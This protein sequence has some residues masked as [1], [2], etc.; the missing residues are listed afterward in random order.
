MDIRVVPLAES[1][2]NSLIGY[3]VFINGDQVAQAIADATDKVVQAQLKKL[4]WS[5]IEPE[6]KRLVDSLTPEQR[7]VLELTAK[8]F[9]TQ[10]IADIGKISLR[11]AESRRTRVYQ[12]L[13]VGSIGEASV[14]AAKAG[15][16]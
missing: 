9:T 14:I 5:R 8:G 1:E 13:N 7:E 12:L 2:S 6:L 16:V 3:S 11:A 15:L 10:E 4:G